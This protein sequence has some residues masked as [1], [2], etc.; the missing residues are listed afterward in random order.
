MD[1]LAAELGDECAPDLTTV[2]GL[3]GRAVPMDQ[4]EYGVGSQILRDLGVRRL[5]VL[6]N[7]PKH[8][9]GLHAFGLEIVENVAIGG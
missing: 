8:L 5:R 4:R 9:P 3:G 1:H 2:N 6:T 7:A